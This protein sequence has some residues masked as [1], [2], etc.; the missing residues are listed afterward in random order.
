MKGLDDETNIMI[1]TVTYQKAYE[2]GK[3]LGYLRAYG[4]EQKKYIHE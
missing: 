2:K 1:Q 3:E 4:T